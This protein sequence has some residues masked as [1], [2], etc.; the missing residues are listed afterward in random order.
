MS[1]IKE[2]P[3][4][5][6]WC[7]VKFTK[8]WINHKFLAFIVTTVMVYKM[9]FEN[10]F[11][12]EVMERLAVIIVWGIVSLFF[13]LGK[14]IDNAFYNMKITAELKAGAQAN[15]NADTAKIIEAVKGVKT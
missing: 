8:G 12:L 4:K 1:D 14:S 2:A 3:V 15:I 5:E 6:K 11:N 9:M 13:I 10:I 7:W